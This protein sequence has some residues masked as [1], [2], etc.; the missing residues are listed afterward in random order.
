MRKGKILLFFL[1]LLPG[2]LRSEAP[3]AEKYLVYCAGDS[4]MRPLPVHLRRLLGPLRKKTEIREWA[5]GGQSTQTFP[6]FL[7]S[8]YPRWRE[9]ACDFVLLQLG[10]NDIIPLLHK[11]ITLD[12][13][14]K[15]VTSLVLGFKGLKGRRFASPVVM[16]ATVPPILAEPEGAEKRKVI[17]ELVNPLLKEISSSCGVLLVD[18]HAVL[19]DRPDL[20]DPDGIHPNREGEIAL[21]RNWLTGLKASIRTG[22]PPSA[23]KTPGP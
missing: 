20:F 22:R 19:K 9:K 12:R 18:N 13:F 11:E 16:M 8:R 15:A 23:P 5:Q 7:D 10:T 14:K 3:P 21:A 17:E 4:L 1:A 2:I 6:S